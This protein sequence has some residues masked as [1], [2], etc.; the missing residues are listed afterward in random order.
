LD[1][2]K[3][4]R[5]ELH[6]ERVELI[7]VSAEGGNELNEIKD[8]I[9]IEYQRRGYIPAHLSSFDDELDKSSIYFGTYAND[10]LLAAARL[11]ESKELPTESLYYKFDMPQPLVNCTRDKLR[12]VSRL[13]VLKRPGDNPLPR[14]FTSTLMISSLIDYGFGRGLCGGV[15]TIKLSFLRLFDSMNLPAL[16]EITD[17]ELTYPRDGILS[18][19]F[20][21]EKSPAVPIYYLH[22]EAKAIFD[23]L[24]HNVTRTHKTLLGDPLDIL[25]YE[26]LV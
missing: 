26:V 24:F 14:H 5:L 15:S 19:F 18:N 12:E 1:I 21:D 8:M 22:D 6:G 16:H 11:I 9:R 7:S 23:G 2:I 10:V 20:Y 3:R 4:I 13:T 25:S 17:A